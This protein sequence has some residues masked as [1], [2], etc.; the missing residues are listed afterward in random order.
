[1]DRALLLAMMAQVSS[2]YRSFNEFEYY[3]EDFDWWFIPCLDQVANYEAIK[4]FNV[5]HANVA[6]YKTDLAMVCGWVGQQL[7]KDMKEKTAKAWVK[8]EKDPWDIEYV[9]AMF[10]CVEEVKYLASEFKEFFGEVEA[11]EAIVPAVQSLFG[12]AE[13]FE[14]F[15]E[16]NLKTVIVQ[17]DAEHLLWLQDMMVEVPDDQVD[18]AAQDAN[19]EVELDLK[20]QPI[21]PFVKLLKSENQGGQTQYK[22]ETQFQAKETDLFKGIVKGVVMPAGSP[23][24]KYLDGDWFPAE[25]IEEAMYDYM[26]NRPYINKEHDQG[27]LHLMWEHPDFAVVENYIAPADFVMGGDLVRKGDWV[28]TMVAKNEQARMDLKEGKYNGFSI[29]AWVTYYPEEIVVRN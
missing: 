1:M 12:F 29:E 17:A 18:P 10:R 3:M 26:L 21:K 11:P 4:A 23:D 15:V 24:R 28:Q 22:I 8:R 14:A 6:Q 9:N 2:F 27:D 25:M 13:P 20:S 19:L 16:Q 7:E 5:A